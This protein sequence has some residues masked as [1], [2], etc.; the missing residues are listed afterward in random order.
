MNTCAHHRRAL[1][2]RLPDGLI[3]LSGGKEIP[4]NYDVNYV[5]RQHSN[6]LYLT[7][8][9]EPD[10]HLLLDPKRRT[11]TLFLPR[12][13]EHHRVWE[14]HVP[15]PAEAK[16]LYGVPRVLYCDALPAE[17]KR[18][19]KGYR[20]AYA[21]AASWKHSGSALKGLHKASLTLEDAIE[22]LRTI[23]T[24]GE[25][26]RMAEANRISGRAHELVMRQ[27]RAGMREY[28]VQALFE[29]ECLRSGQR[30][31][32]YPS[33]VAAGKNGAVLHYR[34]N[35]AKLKKG[36][37]LLI[38]AGVEVR[39]Y[40]ADITRTFPVS[41]R[42]SPKQRDVY[43]VVLETQKACIDA[44]RPGLNSAAWH[45]LSMRLIADGL[46]DMKLLR[47]SIDELVETGA[48]RLFYPH[49]IGHLLGLD[50]HDGLG[51][52]R[53]KKP[54][55]TKV[56]VRFVADLEPGMAVTVEPGVYFIDA[57]LNSPRL[58]RKHRDQVDFTRAERFLDLGGVRIEDDIV[59]R[60]SGPPRN[61]TSVAKEIG[62]IEALRRGV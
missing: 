30:H 36:Q 56:P 45:V 6:F 35:D 61:L 29:A 17:I 37:L 19:R 25:L 41:S 46:R 22:E 31:L 5:F 48:V 55:P 28:E 26:E 47:G 20:R 10:C 38:D 15:G 50:V 24:P 4:R 27:T 9:E 13:D 43:S 54:N 42:F 53:R 3:L 51:G 39:G 11:S 8:V 33:I 52:K 57:L 16:T 60:P 12:I 58:R 40:A 49:G 59:V 7:G 23:K 34:R 62:D 44:A 14:G 18:A 2:R 32:A 21:D 1:M